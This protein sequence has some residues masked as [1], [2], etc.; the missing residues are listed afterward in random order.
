LDGY[1][2]MFVW[3][4][5]FG[6][7]ALTVVYALLSGGA[8]KGLADNPNRAGVVVA[9]LIGLAISVGAVFGGIYKQ[10]HPLNKV[11]IVAAIWLVIGVAVT[12]FGGR[13]PA[14]RAL[15]ELRSASQGEGA[16]TGE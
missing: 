8:F 3:L 5:T 11:W 14:S 16:G 13:E 2:P 12:S 15:S 10:P 1:F 4:S 9:G 6:G 7:F